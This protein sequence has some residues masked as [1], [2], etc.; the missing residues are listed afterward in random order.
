MVK[1]DIL[2]RV[3]GALF[4]VAIGDSLGMPTEFLSRDQVKELYGWVDKFYQAPEWHP[5]NGLPAGSITDDTE[6]TIAMAE[7]VIENRDFST[8]DV[9]NALLKWGKSGKM[10]LGLDA[11]GPSTLGALKRLEAGENPAQTGLTGKTNGAAIRI[12]PIAAV[13]PGVPPVLIEKVVELCIPTH[14][15][16]IAVSGACAVASWISAG[17]GGATIEEAL[18]AALKGAVAGREAFREKVALELEGTIPWE[19]M[20]AQINPYLEHRIMWA[21]ENALDQTK[22]WEERYEIAIRTLGTSVDMIETVPVSI[23]VALIADGDPYKAACLGANAGGDTDSIASVAS[24]LVG[25][26]SGTAGFPK[27][28]IDQL[29]EVNDIDLESLG[30]RLANAAD[31]SALTK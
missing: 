31:T 24:A 12:S 16:D 17:I 18:E 22:S 3:Q 23:A 15:T 8:G 13:Y 20:S 29:Q 6:Q 30:E 27:S 1:Q 25:A 26:V 19:V 5:L 7:M 28:L 4:G 10:D 9:V 21:V 2:D 11:M 14:F